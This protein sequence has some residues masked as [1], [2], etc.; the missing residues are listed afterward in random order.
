[1]ALK[2]EAVG[3]GV[4][5]ELPLV[6]VDVLARRPSTGLPTKTEQADLFQAVLG[7]NGESPVAVL[8][9]QSP[10]DCSPPLSRPAAS[11]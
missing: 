4:M 1:M 2:M 11:R 10:A 6:V 8:A 3:L 7:R 5:T 9:A